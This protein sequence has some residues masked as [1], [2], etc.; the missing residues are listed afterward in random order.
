LRAELFQARFAVESVIDQRSM[1]PL[2][3]EREG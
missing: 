3:V 2:I 1:S